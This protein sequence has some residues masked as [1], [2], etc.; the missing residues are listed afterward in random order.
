MIF[1][2]LVA[3]RHRVRS[4]LSTDQLL[5]LELLL[6][7]LRVYAVLLAAEVRVL[8]LKALVVR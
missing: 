8:A 6:L 2:L 7:H 4:A 5:R 3:A 1:A